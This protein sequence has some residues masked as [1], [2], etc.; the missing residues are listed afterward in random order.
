MSQEKN[1]VAVI[2]QARLSS[3]R[4]PQKIVKM[5]GEKTLLQHVLETMK[6]VPAA[7]YVLACDEASKEVCAPIAEKAGFKCISGSETDV[8][9]R[10][11]TVLDTLEADE[12]IPE[13]TAVVRATA[14]NPFLFAEAAKAS[15]ERF[16]DLPSCDYF[17]FTGLPHG[18]GV[19]IL[20]AAT[21]RYMAEESTDAYEREHVGP[22]LYHHP[23]DFKC[24]REAA[25]RKWY[26]PDLRTT[27]DTIEDFRRAERC[28]FHLTKNNITVPAPAEYII[29][30]CEEASRSVV[31]VPSI[32]K[33]GGSGHV[34]RAITLAQ[35]LVPSLS[36]SVYLPDETELSRPVIKEFPELVCRE[37][38]AQSSLIVLDNFRSSEGLIRHLQKRAPVV[39]LDEGGNGRFCADYLLDIIP[40]LP[41]ESD[42]EAL[43]ANLF[44]PAFITLPKKRKQR[45]K[46]TRRFSVNKKRHRVLVVCG[47]E[48]DSRSAIPIASNIAAL[49][50][51]VTAID[52][53]VSFED[54]ASRE[55]E[56][57][58]S[59]GIPNLREQLVEW[60]I[61]VTHYGFTAFEAATAGLAVVLVSPTEIH[62]ELGRYY[63][64]SS[65]AEAV[66]SQA[67]FARLFSRGI[68]FP[69]VFEPTMVQ[70]NL[71]DH[72][73]LL[74]GGQR[75]DCPLCGCGEPES[76]LIRGDDR[77]VAK[78]SSCE[79]QYLRFIAGK[80]KNYSESYFFDEYK[81]QYGKTYL[82]DFEAIK[83]QG[84][85]RMKI[86]EECFSTE[87]TESE[88]RMIDI[89]CAYG[90]I[91][92]AAHDLGWNAVGTDISE[93]AI[94]HILT[95]LQLP[96]FSTAF[97][98]MPEAV[99][100]H[101]D[102]K[103]APQLIDLSNG[104]FNA[105][106]MWFVIEHFPNLEAVLKKCAELLSVGG[107]FA[108]STPNTAGVTGRFF[109]RKFFM[110]SPV[111][112]YSLWDERTAQKHLARFG[113]KIKKIVSVG[114][115]PERFPFCKN[116]RKGGLLFKLLHAISRR[117]NLGDS[118][119]IYAIKIAEPEDNIMREDVMDSLDNLK[120]FSGGAKK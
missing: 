104:S 101:I 45:H 115:H 35:Q 36:V 85:R 40:S 63:G 66:P 96:A 118:M 46:K 49:G 5:L 33:G 70:H 37:I 90:P 13:I 9:R 39:A 56:F 34:R 102:A 64:F 99:S 74:A 116:I 50:F 79:M 43:Q 27:V 8:L 12:T 94:R 75:L 4:L 80:Q 42:E 52:P 120:S 113:F 58:L 41:L 110:Q 29:S 84:T 62:Y 93:D 18:S 32:R 69:A 68:I 14:D 95:Q 21:L 2:V 23:A 44:D 7:A 38:P 17:T 24:V 3:V 98:A 31:F 55:G 26:N 81:A 105:V 92:S 47:G 97:P 30:A 88:K 57:S 109:P 16:F 60:D 89:G 65:F 20:R 61:V 19:E 91:I 67:D 59:A 114:H 51:D 108:F 10:F 6:T 1:G 119:E 53:H 73:E 72:L 82:E 112:H 76:I 117:F 25:P 83:A 111:D 22:A 87:N 78:C 77:T 11:A 48:D 71:V 107:V 86:V 103:H 28:L 106:T 54:I 100:V 15:V